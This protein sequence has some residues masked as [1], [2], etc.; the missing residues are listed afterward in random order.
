MPPRAR[1][2]EISPRSGSRTSVRPRCSGSARRA[3][4]CT[5][6][7]SG[8]TGELPSAAGR[9]RR[10]L[11]RERT[12]LVPDP[13]FSATKL[14]WLLRETSG[15]PAELAFGNVDSWLV[16]QLTGGAVHATDVSNASRT[17]L[18]GLESLEWDDELLELF[19][20]PREILPR[21][22]DSSGLIAEADFL[23]T[24]VPI[25]G[26]AGD[27][28]AALFGQGCHEPGQVKATY[29]TG[30]FVLANAGSDAGRHPK[31]S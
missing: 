4:R 11:V 20:V 27:Q 17:M 26:I 9:S 28:Q 3:A 23:G 7:S 22:V 19:G 16:W 1:E 2:P 14:E 31:A 10:D 25:T 12:G 8:R 21:V 13:Y 29:G 18:L 24:R 5:A 6:R 30:S 15:D